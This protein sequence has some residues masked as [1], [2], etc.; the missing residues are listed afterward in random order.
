MMKGRLLRQASFC[1]DIG[2]NHSCGLFRYKG[3]LIM[4]FRWSCRKLWEENGGMA[5]FVSCNGFI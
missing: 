4:G 2:Y 5:G 1:G 3:F